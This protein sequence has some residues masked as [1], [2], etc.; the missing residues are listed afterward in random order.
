MTVERHRRAID[1]A[2]VNRWVA[3]YEDAWRSEGTDRLAALFTDDVTYRA[4]PW[5][6]PIHGIVALGGFW[7]AERDGPD[8]VFM[9]SS[10]VV[11]VDSMTAVVRVEVDY[12]HSRPWRDLW[13]L[14]FAE[15]GRVAAFEEWPFAP[16]TLDGH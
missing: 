1:R 10:A 16:D 2:M 9:M 5:R 3:G 8:E 4:S 7:E 13:V 12:E 11:A 15:D 6:E 14:R